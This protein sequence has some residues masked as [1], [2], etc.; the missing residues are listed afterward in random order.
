MPRLGFSVAASG[1]PRLP[2]WGRPDG[3]ELEFAG[4]GCCVPIHGKRSAA[5]WEK[6]SLRC[7]WFVT[8]FWSS[9]TWLIRRSLAV[10]PT[11]EI[12]RKC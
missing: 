10:M 8:K 11:R 5:D 9:R 3:L 2:G 7:H 12:G 6:V 1:R 4:G